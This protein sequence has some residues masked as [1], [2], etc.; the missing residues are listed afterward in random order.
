MN[1][2]IGKVT[3]VTAKNPAEELER[4]RLTV[5]QLAEHLGNVAKACRRGGLDRTRFYEWKRRFQT[6][7]LEGL[8]TCR[9]SRA[10]T[11]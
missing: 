8:R 2:M 10:I 5:L 7:G 3:G 6:H 9:R 4:K 1:A 11:R